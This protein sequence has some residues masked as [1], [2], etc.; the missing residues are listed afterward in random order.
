MTGNEYSYLESRL[1]TYDRLHRHSLESLGQAQVLLADL[2][3]QSG[4]DAEPDL[5]ILAHP[6]KP[7][8][9]WTGAYPSGIDGIEVLNLKSI[10][11]QAWNSSKISF[12][13]SA[14]IYPFNL[15]LALLRLYEEPG[16]ELNLWD[17]L[18]MKA[19]TI[20]MAGAEATEKT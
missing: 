14:I 8:F 13:W 6:S 17:Q 11:Q 12:L 20:G 5:I 7:G 2:L 18:S 3:S 1:L 15:Q 4:P 9:S 19:N 16:E 10:W